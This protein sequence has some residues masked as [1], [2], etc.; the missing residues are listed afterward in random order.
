MRADWLVK[1]QISFAIY[2]RATW[3]K[4]ASWFV[5]I[6][7]EEIIQINFFGVYYLAVLVC[8]LKQLFTWVLVVSDIY[9]ATSQLDKYPPLA[10]STNPGH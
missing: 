4:M 3:E 10:T 1:L 5:S 2:L 8:T 9:L 7:S 6:T